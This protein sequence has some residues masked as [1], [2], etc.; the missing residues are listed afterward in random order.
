MNLDQTYWNNAENPSEEVQTILIPKSHHHTIDCENAK[1]E[2]LDK[3]KQVEKFDRV[4][5]IGQFCISTTWVV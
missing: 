5:D 4:P 3:L 1:E 2:Q